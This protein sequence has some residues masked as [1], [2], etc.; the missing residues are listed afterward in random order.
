MSGD[1]I[2][3]WCM[4][5][6]FVGFIALCIIFRDKTPSGALR[7]KRVET[8]SGDVRFAVEEYQRWHG[9]DCDGW[10]WNEIASYSTEQGAR[11]HIAEIQ[12]KVIK[13]EEVLP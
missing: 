9:Y 3:C 6:F 2:F 1:E 11:G 13:S 7:V 10:E 5:L 12:G 4:G 8:C